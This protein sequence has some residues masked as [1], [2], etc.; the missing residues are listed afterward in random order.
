VRSSTDEGRVV[1]LDPRIIT[2]RYG[3]MFLDALPDGIVARVE[4]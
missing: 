2:K 1:V 3:R 4:E